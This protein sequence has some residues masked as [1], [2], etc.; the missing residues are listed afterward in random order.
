MEMTLF[1]NFMIMVLI[2]GGVFGSVFFI[3]SKNGSKKPKDD[4]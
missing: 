4:K 3:A 1:Y 2:T